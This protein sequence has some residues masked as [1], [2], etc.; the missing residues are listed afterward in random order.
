[1][2]EVV[3]SRNWVS[4]TI[5]M[6]MLVH[7]NARA[8]LPAPPPLLAMPVTLAWNAVEDPSV[9]GYALY[10]GP[11]NQPATNRV[12][13][14]A[15][16]TATIA[17]MLANVEYRIYAVSYAADGLESL[18]SNELL[19]TLPAISRLKLARQPD[20]SMRLTGRAAPGT[21]CN[22]LFTSTLYPTIWELLGESIADQIGNFV[23]IDDTAGQA[24]QRFYRVELGAK[25][26]IGATQAP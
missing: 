9:S 23:T 24:S 5:G 17:G 3:F 19:L 11:A 10:Y 26:L 2:K 8:A 22:V 4:L 13:A 6:I 15:T 20:G 18:P 21:V 12:D 25:R 14:G 1:M 16:T 7:W